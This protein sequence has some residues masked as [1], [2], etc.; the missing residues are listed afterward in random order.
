MAMRI[1]GFTRILIVLVI[2]TVAL[3]LYAA[4]WYWWTSRVPALSPKLAGKRPVV[5]S[6]LPQAWRELDAAALDSSLEQGYIE[7][8]LRA[9]GASNNPD[10]PAT[11]QELLLTARYAHNVKWTARALR[12]AKDEAV[13]AGRIGWALELAGMAVQEAQRGKLDAREMASYYDEK[14]LMERD[15]AM[16]YAALRDYQSEEQCLRAAGADDMT[17]GACTADQMELCAFRLGRYDTALALLPAWQ[18]TTSADDMQGDAGLAT[19][20]PCL[21]AGIYRDWG[22]P[23]EALAL[24]S[25][26]AQTALRDTNPKDVLDWHLLAQAYAGLGCAEETTRLYKHIVKLTPV[27]DPSFPLPYHYQSYYRF[28]IDME[29]EEEAGAFFA[30][31]MKNIAAAGPALRA[32]RKT[33]QADYGKKSDSAWAAEIIA[34]AKSTMYD[35]AGLAQLNAGDGQKAKGYFQQAVELSRSPR[36]SLLG[37]PSKNGLVRTQLELGEYEAA[38]RGIAEIIAGVSQDRQKSSK[39]ELAALWVLKARIEI[40][41]GKLDDARRDLDWATM[42]LRDA[43]ADYRAS[44][45]EAILALGELAEKQGHT[46]LAVKRYQAAFDAALAEARALSYSGYLIRRYG[47]EMRRAA[48][49]LTPLLQAQGDQAGLAQLEAQ[50]KSL[51]ALRRIVLGSYAPASKEAGECMGRY[52]TAKTRMLALKE[53]DAQ[54]LSNSNTDISGWWRTVAHSRGAERK[55]W[56]AVRREAMQLHRELTPEIAKQ[57]A[58]AAQALAELQRLDPE[59][60]ALLGL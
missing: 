17:L 33:S 4:G 3:V 31:Y 9:N 13:K 2:A 51:E 55:R 32:W 11:W 46:A 30:A 18:K 57:E 10:M 16:S 14:A 36:G 56:L 25:G 42:I 47:A 37:R 24:L 38:S 48:A 40:G 7:M 60:A 1:R 54:S 28:M 50:R 44:Q 12:G 35:E 20:Y 52:R 58:L 49:K 23:A 26:L 41:S 8:G 21:W 45:R 27:I 53:V 29:R 59:T 6:D 22:M 34:N 5:N 19:F 39:L 15:T 43:P